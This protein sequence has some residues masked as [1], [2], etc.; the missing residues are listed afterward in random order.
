MEYSYV[1]GHENGPKE[2]D[3]Y[4]LNREQVSCQQDA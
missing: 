2:A 3:H 1:L 4:T